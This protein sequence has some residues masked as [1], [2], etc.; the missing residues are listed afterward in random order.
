[1]ET[2]H[3]E[4]IR[5]SISATLPLLRE[6]AGNSSPEPYTIENLWWTKINVII[7]II[8]AIMGAI[9][10]W[11]GYK[12]FVQ[13]RKTALNVVRMSID[14]QFKLCASLIF[15]LI[16]N[17]VRA[18]VVSINKENGK[19]PTENYISSFTISDFQDIFFP[20]S[21]NQK[22]DAYLALSYVKQR[23]LH[24]KSLLNL[25]GGHCNQDYISQTDCKD[26]LEK[27]I[28]IIK[29]IFSFVDDISPEGCYKI[30]FELLKKISSIIPMSISAEKY[31]EIRKE[32]SELRN[33]KGTPLILEDTIITNKLSANP[34]CNIESYNELKKYYAAEDISIFINPDIDYDNIKKG[35][36]IVMEYN[37]IFESQF[38]TSK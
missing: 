10:A 37:I 30:K 26:L 18:G 31:N 38:F 20:E 22:P 34:L 23:L 17:Y 12:G 2:E 15:D 4:V 32:I 9:G 16:R 19:I 27:P 21:F 6:L 1:M 25:V 28:K 7:S 8:A 33:S 13:S 24:Y 3:L 29:S 5:D 36:Q 35:L 14:T 11:Y